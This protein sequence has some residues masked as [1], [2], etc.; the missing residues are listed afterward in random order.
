MLKIECYFE[1]SKQYSEQKSFPFSL[2]LSLCSHEFQM[3][4]NEYTFD[5]NFKE[6]SHSIYTDITG[7]QYLN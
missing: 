1:Y 7:R 6:N 3:V 5:L 2:L 4:P